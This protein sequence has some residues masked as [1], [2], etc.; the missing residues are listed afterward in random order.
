MF[1]FI[2]AHKTEILAAALAVSELLALIPAFA[3]NGILDSIIKLL[4]K[5]AA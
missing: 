2:T 4:K 5:P 3:G 1:D